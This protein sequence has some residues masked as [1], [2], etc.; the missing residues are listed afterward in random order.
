MS[1]KKEGPKSGSDGKDKG[2]DVPGHSEERR[3]PL[4][5]GTRQ[6]NKGESDK[7]PDTGSGTRRG[8]EE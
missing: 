7:R 5:E 4:S 2:R 3:R 6:V 8:K 1:D